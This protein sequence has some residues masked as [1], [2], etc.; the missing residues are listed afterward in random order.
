MV[1]I[2]RTYLAIEPVLPSFLSS[3]TDLTVNEWFLPGEPHGADA[4]PP[5]LVAMAQWAMHYLV[6]HPQPPRNYE[7][8]FQIAPLSC[9]PALGDHEHDRIAVG[10]A[11]SRME[12][13]FIAMREMTGMGV[14]MEV[15]QAIRSRLISYV[16]DDGLCWCDPAA[17]GERS[18]EAAANPWTTG[19]LL[20]STT[21]LYIRSGDERE[22]QF[23][24]RLA[25]GLKNLAS[26]RGYL[27]WYEGGAAS[28]RDGQW[29]RSSQDLPAL[30]IDPLYRYWRATG[31]DD[32]LEFVEGMAEGLVANVQPTLHNS[33]VNPDGSHRSGNNHLMMRAAMGVAEVGVATSNARLIEWA[34]RLYEFTRANGTDWGWYPENMITPEKRYWSETCITGDMVECAVA[35]TR[36]G[37][38]EY[39][40]HVERTARNYLPWAQ[41][42]LRPD[43]VE[44]YRKTHADKSADEVRFG[45][46]MLR[47]FEGGFLARQRPN[48]WVY[49]RDGNWQVNMMG[50]CPPS[51]MRALHQAWANTVV[52]RDGVVYVNMSLNRDAPSAKVTACARRQGSLVIEARR[53]ADYHVRP[54]AWAPLDQVIATRNDK[55]VKPDWYRAYVRFEKVKRGE[56]LCIGY[57]LPRFT[58]HQLIGC[59]L[60]EESYEVHW[61]GNDVQ[62]VKPHGRF[63]PIFHG[64]R[65]ELPRLPSTVNWLTGEILDPAPGKIVVFDG[66]WQSQG[67]A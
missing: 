5:D 39:W 45:L 7:C 18:S 23:G 46:K 49:R 15:E 13:E 32:V 43:F 35:L 9:P 24:R 44:L 21:E 10:D 59:E 56:R 62:Q 57:P 63:L 26:E 14:G 60:A 67:I 65:P 36:A 11:E 40:D 48:D 27:K 54:P 38:P 31:E 28:L 34:R 47:R 50:C 2:M 6:C 64:P 30:I 20:R 19:Y 61:L 4:E 42:F 51:G 16:R 37:Y 22:R 25:D 52:D 17:L 41:F 58:Q 8:R 3:A 66:G 1:C 33:H 55:P 53:S 29:L 12:L